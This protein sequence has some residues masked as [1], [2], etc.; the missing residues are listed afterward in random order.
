[1]NGLARAYAGPE[2]GLGGMRRRA[3]RSRLA[4]LRFPSAVTLSRL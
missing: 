4:R 1:V 2:V 3:V